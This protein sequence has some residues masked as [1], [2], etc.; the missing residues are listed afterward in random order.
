MN[1]VEFHILLFYI[2]KS[3]I[4]FLEKDPKPTVITKYNT[5]HWLNFLSI[6]KKKTSILILLLT[7]T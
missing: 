1:K 3:N 2:K 6:Y 4:K 7:L 5:V